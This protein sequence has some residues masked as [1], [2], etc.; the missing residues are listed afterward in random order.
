MTSAAAQP[1]T[2]SLDIRPVS[3]A[4]GAE[5][6]GV[7]LA[8]ETDPAI[9]DALRSAIAEHGVI[10]FRDQALTPAQ[11]IA[12]AE[13]FAPININ[14]FFTH[15]EDY[16]QIAEV[17]KE[18]EQKNNIGGGW[19]TDHSYDIAPAFGSILL[20][21]EVPAQGGD[22]QFADLALA[23]DKL[24]EGLKATLKTLSAVHSS[25]H[26]FG[27]AAVR[28]DDLTSRIGNADAAT[29]DAIHPMVIRH[30]ESGRQVLFVNP[31]F[32][33]RID[34]WTAEES[35]PLLDYLYEHA[36][37]PEFTCRFRWANGSI[38][39]W[40]NRRTWHQ[41]INDYDGVR[42]LMHRITLEGVPI[43]A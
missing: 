34:G 36:K 40:D 35:K 13:Q 4:L 7:D 1:Q 27:K 3:G 33:L 32:T 18:P 8:G 29:Q 42:R 25:R 41:A 15:A 26:V 31:G 21:R 11:H 43:S 2:G 24:S 22:T 37:R 30:P 6:H 10:F 38:A 16:P 19:H 5:I 23:Y 39:F 20:A 28:P 9:W 14:R 17:R 12:M